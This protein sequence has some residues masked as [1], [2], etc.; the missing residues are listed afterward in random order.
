[1]PRRIWIIAKKE[2]VEDSDIAEA[3]LSHCPEITNGIPLALEAIISSE[4]LPCIY[5]EP[6]LP[7]P[8]VARDLAAEIDD[9]KARVESL[10]KK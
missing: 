3:T 2:K 10:E 9:L 7:E 5:E 4:Q 1:M 8:E 6:E